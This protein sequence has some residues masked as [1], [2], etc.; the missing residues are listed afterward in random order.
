[1]SEAMDDLEQRLREFAKDR[2]FM[3]KESNLA[4]QAADRLRRYR[5]ALES[6][7]AVCSP[8]MLIWQD[9]DIGQIVHDALQEQ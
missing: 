2:L 4:S 3:A 1:M 5:E 9:A 8:H 7:S 6:I